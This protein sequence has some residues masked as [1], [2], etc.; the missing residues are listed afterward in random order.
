MGGSIF[1]EKNGGEEIDY[2]INGGEETDYQKMGGG[3]GLTKNVR[4]RESAPPLQS[5]F[6]HTPLYTIARILSLSPL[7]TWT[8][9]VEDFQI[10]YDHSKGLSPFPIKCLYIYC[11]VII[12]K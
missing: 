9:V 7:T 10:Y 12:K 2:Q 4:P 11:T 1:F 5:F 8:V 6:W 3:D